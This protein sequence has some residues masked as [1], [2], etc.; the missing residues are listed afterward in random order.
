MD[1]ACKN[2]DLK[3]QAVAIVVFEVQFNY[4][5][6]CVNGIDGCIRGK[7]NTILKNPADIIVGFEK[8]F[9]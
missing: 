2:P 8:Q 4:R 1:A 3:N 6:Y 9:K 7:K 5:N